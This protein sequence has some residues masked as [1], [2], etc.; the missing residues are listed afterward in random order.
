[1][2]GA[3]DEPFV[4]EGNRD[5]C[6]PISQRTGAQHILETVSRYGPGESPLRVNPAAEEAFY[7]VA[8]EGFCEVAGVS[9]ELRSGIAGFLPPGMSYRFKNVSPEMLTVVSVRCP[10]EEPVEA[11]KPTPSPAQ[12]PRLTLDESERTAQRSGDRQFKLLVDKDVGCQQVTQFIGIIPPSKAPFHF[13]TYE[14]AIYILEGAGM[15]H[16]GEPGSVTSAGFAA[17]SSIFLPIGMPHCVENPGP[18][19]VRLLGVFYPS[20]SPATRYD[21]A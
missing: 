8:G 7:V 20:G 9:Y 11:A 13:H 12:R 4:A 1:V 21:S 6:V 18:G 10:Q 3:N 15:V 19:V 14:E 16:A 2:V 17:G 5:F